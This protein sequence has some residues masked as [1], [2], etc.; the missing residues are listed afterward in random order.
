MIGIKMLFIRNKILLVILIFCGKSVF[1]QRADTCDLSLVKK[2]I[3][4][5][6]LNEFLTNS[7][8]K[9]FVNTNYNDRFQCFYLGYSKDGGYWSGVLMLINET[10]ILDSACKVI[11]SD[12]QYKLVPVKM[13]KKAAFPEIGNFSSPDNYFIKDYRVEDGFNELL[14]IK[15]K[16]MLMNGIISWGKSVPADKLYCNNSMANLMIYSRKISSK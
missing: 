7:E 9:K 15:D 1:S 14:L 8:V 11:F 6:R 5:E 12:Q 16:N 4:I 3:F 2:D 13:K 10:G